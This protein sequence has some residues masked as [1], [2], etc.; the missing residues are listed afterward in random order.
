MKNPY[1]KKY[2]FLNNKALIKI[3][4]AVGGFLV[5]ISFIQSFFYIINLLVFSF[6][7]V[8]EDN[9]FIAIYFGLLIIFVIF[10]GLIGIVVNYKIAKNQYDLK[11]IKEK[12]DIKDEWVD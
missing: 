8:V 6:S 1:S 12:L 5:A 4:S 7:T 10:L 2:K 11:R 9:L 3:L